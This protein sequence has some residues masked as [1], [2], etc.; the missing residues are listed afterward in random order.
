MRCS[1][2]KPTNPR[3]RPHSGHAS[4][5]IASLDQSLKR[6]SCHLHKDIIMNQVHKES[7]GPVIVS[8]LDEPK[9][10]YPYG[11]DSGV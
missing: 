3:R 4:F 5:E 2:L 9:E 8:W 10:E 11:P 1:I 6:Y 7:Q